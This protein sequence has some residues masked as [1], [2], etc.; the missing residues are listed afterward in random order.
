MYSNY[1]LLLIYELFALPVMK[2]PLVAQ[3]QQK[4]PNHLK[5]H[6]SQKTSITT[7]KVTK[8]ITWT[9]IQDPSRREL[10]EATKLFPFHAVHINQCLQRGHIAQMTV[11]D[12][13]IFLLLYFPYLVAT[14]TRGENR[15]ATSQVSVFLGKDYLVTVHESTN[16]NIERLFENFT[17]EFASG[18]NH[19]PVPP[20]SA[21]ESIEYAFEGAD[22]RSSGR[23]LYH[24]IESLLADVASLTE[25]VS[26]E[27]DAIEDN[28]FD[29]KGSDALQIGRL[30]QKIMRLRRTLAA[31]KSVLDELDAVI[32]E[33]TG[34]HLRRYYKIN[35][36]M[37]RKLWE[38][39]EE[40]G[41]TVEIY[42]DADF[43]T[44]T[45]KTNE[46]LAV[47]TL[48]FTLTIPATVIGTFYGMNII[49]PGGLSSVAWSFLGEYTTLKLIVGTSIVSAAGMYIYFKN[50]HWI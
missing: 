12:D 47:L 18:Q 21:V 23:I 26:Q 31:Q 15:I 48:L 1:L 39:V 45:E 5:T 20:H 44:S 27:L 49:L 10:L 34:E 11:E 29:D 7:A 28:V 9:D 35:T 33:F 37:S 46:I 3:S 6:T 24:I 2:A 16:L 43:T 17:T 4:A 50:K 19:K 41:E 42:K 25:L 32:D 13:Y 36:N 38:T 8:G 30:R 22:A 14:D 40:A